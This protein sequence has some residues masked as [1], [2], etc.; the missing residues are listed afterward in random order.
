MKHSRK[1]IPL[2]ILISGSGT[3]M[4]ALARAARAGRLGG[5]KIAV[6]ICT[7]PDAAGIG[8]ALKLGL[9]VV[10]IDPRDFSGRAA[11]EAAVHETLRRFKVKYILLAGYM[12][13]LTPAFFKGWKNRILN[14]HP[15]LLPAFR[16]AHG[17]RDALAWGAKVSG[18]T[19]HFVEPALDDGPAI[20]QTAVPVLPRDTE[21]TLA[22]RILKAEH[23]AY[24]A[25][26]RALCEGRLSVRG[27]R[28]MWR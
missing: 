11:H 22:A 18:C 26:V 13:I 9:P 28:V 23:R 16:G 27:R 6:V 20:L 3:N 1:P 4:V 25:A 21:K 12:R 19:I 14:T 15:A 5:G 17:T 24:P 10:V 2:A 7:D 8:K